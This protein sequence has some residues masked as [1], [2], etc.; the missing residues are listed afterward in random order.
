MSPE[1]RDPGLLHD[2]LRA[3][4]TALRLTGDL[5]AEAFLEDERTHFAVL[6]Q[7]MII[8]EA[9]NRL[10]V[11]AKGAMDLPWKRIVGQRHVVVHDYG[12]IDLNEIW[13]TVRNDLPTLI[14]IVE[15][16]LAEH[17]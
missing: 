6:H 5:P 11:S 8:G 17:P 3:A 7:L 12:R 2:M 4:R 10:S 15:R 1:E 13:K 9:A 16:Y 14:T